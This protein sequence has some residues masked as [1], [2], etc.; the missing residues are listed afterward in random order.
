MKIEEVTVE[1]AIRYRKEIA[2]LYFENVRS[3]S[4][5]EQY[6]YEEAYEKIGG[7]IGHLD[8]QTAVVF[9]AFEEEM[10]CG[11][12]WAYI[13]PFRE[14]IRMYVNEIRVKEEYRKRGIGT[15]LIN[16][17]EKKAKELG[18]GTIYLH[19]EGTNQVSRTFYTVCGY[20]E[21]RVQY[22]KRL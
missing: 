9:G 13:H 10:L 15:M 12:I 18:I 5:L 16:E 21:E 7:M 11:F 6:T 2:E 14:E 3:C 22:K 8:D 20:D 17:V 19:A 1:A 4:G